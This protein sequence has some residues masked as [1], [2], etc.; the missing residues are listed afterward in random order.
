MQSNEPGGPIV[1]MAEL[2]EPCR[3][4]THAA[5]GIKSGKCKHRHCLLTA[6]IAT[7]AEASRKTPNGKSGLSPPASSLSFSFLAHGGSSSSSWHTAKPC[8]RWLWGP[9]NVCSACK[10]HSLYLCSCNSA[11]RPFAAGARSTLS[12][13][14]VCVLELSHWLEGH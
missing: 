2:C 14:L 12:E 1:H 7:I 4:Q 8:S 10:L 6:A 5:A 13:M 11:R 9:Q 3:G